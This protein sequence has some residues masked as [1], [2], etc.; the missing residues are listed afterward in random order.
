MHAVPSGSSR[1]GGQDLPK[2]IACASEPRRESLRMLQRTLK[3]EDATSLLE[4]KPIPDI[5]PRA[6]SFRWA[7][8]AEMNVRN[9]HRTIHRLFPPIKFHPTN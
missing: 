9:I 6:H 2:H 7:P 5:L 3:S 8:Q 1:V 4:T